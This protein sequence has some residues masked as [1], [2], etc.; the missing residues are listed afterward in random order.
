[1]KTL[2]LTKYFSLTLE[3]TIDGARERGLRVFA[4][5]PKSSKRVGHASLWIPYGETLACAGFVAFWG[6]LVFAYIATP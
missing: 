5:Y 1:M 3:N 4:K 2:N 6:A